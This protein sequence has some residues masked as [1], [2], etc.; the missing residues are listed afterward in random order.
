MV[1]ILSFY[2]YLKLLRNTTRSMWFYSNGFELVIA[3]KQTI[4]K[5]KCFKTKTINLTHDSVG[6]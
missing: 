3:G 1:R 5:L 6:W 4:L 2:I